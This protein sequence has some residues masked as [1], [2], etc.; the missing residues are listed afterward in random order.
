MSFKARYGFFKNKNV[1][2]TNNFVPLTISVTEN[3]TDPGGAN[4]SQPGVQSV[5]YTIDTN[6]PNATLAYNMTGTAIASDFTDNSLSANIVLDASGNA[7]VT[8]TVVSILYAIYVVN[9]RMK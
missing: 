6:R 4:S 7:T 8:K 3:L 1:I 9:K 2:G 5:V